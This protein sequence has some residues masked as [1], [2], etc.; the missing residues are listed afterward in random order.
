MVSSLLLI[1][2]VVCISVSSFTYAESNGSGYDSITYEILDDGTVALSIVANDSVLRIPAAV[3]GYTVSCITSIDDSHSAGSSKDLK[4]I[5]FPDTITFIGNNP[6]KAYADGATYQ[7]SPNHPYLAVVDD[8]LYSKPDKRLICAPKEY[9]FKNKYRTIPNGTEIIGESAFFSWDNLH[10]EFP[11]S[12]VRINSSA[13]AFSDITFPNLPPRLEYL[14]RGAFSW[15]HTMRMITIP[16]SLKEIPTE[17]FDHSD[18][19][20]I[21]LEEGVEK[22]ADE[23]FAF[24]DRLTTINIPLSLSYIDDS[25]FTGCEKL[26]NIS[27]DAS[28]PNFDYKDDNLIRKS[29]MTLLLYTD[30]WSEV[31]VVPDGIKKLV[32][33]AI[34]MS[35]KIKKIQIP[36]TVEE[37]EYIDSSITMI[38]NPGSF[39]EQYAIENGNLYEYMNESSND[40]LT[41]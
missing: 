37:I 28:N 6:I 21:V 27:L 13:F 9:G 7:V 19:E 33:S 31:Q 8:F 35:K 4:Q 18:I 36:N 14:G 23:A 38:V 1:M 39:A 30:S 10:V 17:A 11:E 16:G 25:A 15:T 22:I 32:R 26:L 34:S 3:D 41:D 2:L 5:W 12:V 29:D 20:E 24:C 40:W